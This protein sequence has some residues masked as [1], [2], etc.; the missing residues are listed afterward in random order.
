MPISATG[1]DPAAAALAATVYEGDTMFGF[2]AADRILAMTHM[3]LAPLLS[4]VAKLQIV[5]RGVDERSTGCSKFI[6]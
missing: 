2:V 3:S 1:D 6:V 5:E 4:V